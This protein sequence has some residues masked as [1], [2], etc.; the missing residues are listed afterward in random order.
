MNTIPLVDSERTTQ[1]RVVN[2]LH[3]Y[4]GY[5]YLGYKQNADN[6]PIIP[7]ILG[8]FIKDTQHASNTEI[9]KVLRLLDLE[10]SRCHDKDTLF[11]SNLNFYS[12]LRY[13][14]NIQGD[15]GHSKTVKIIEWS[16]DNV[17]DNIF[18]LAEEVTVHRNIE[19]YRT[20]RP[21]IVVYVNGMALGVI[22]LKKSTVSVKD[23][24][25][26][27]I[28][29]NGKDNE[30]CNFFLPETIVKECIMVQY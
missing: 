15:D 20:R 9:D 30:I 7:E 25:R 13:G 22:E 12:Y 14:V 6:L 2:L 23:G 29:N 16:E 1:N 21:D 10:I 5:Q 28:R 17:A 8:K 24:V 27:Q 26:Q 4:C 11:Q 18:S 3:D 19:E